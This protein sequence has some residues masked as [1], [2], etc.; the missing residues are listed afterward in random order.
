[1]GIAAA[2]PCPTG[3]R[4][5]D[6]SFPG[7]NDFR[8]KNAN[9]EIKLLSVLGLIVL[10]GGGS[11]FALGRLSGS[12]DQ[13]TPRPPKP[14]SELFATLLGGARHSEGP[15]NAP[16]T[17]LEFADFQCSHC[18]KAFDVVSPLLSSNKNVRFVFRHLPLAK[19]ER[20]LPA[21]IAAEAAGRQNKFWPM[22]ALLFDPKIPED[23]AD[24]AL[25]D[26]YFLQCARKIGLDIA[27]FQRDIKDPALTE[28]VQKDAASAV[29][30]QITST[31]SFLVRDA[32][33]KVSLV[34]G[35]NQLKE[36]LRET[37]SLASV[38]DKQPAT[39]ATP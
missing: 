3:P 12:G 37:A 21:A 10:L 2:V 31:P 24:K 39:A 28:I 27:R 6:F 13:D 17:V 35:G 19:H 29:E 25:T 30:H 22:Y 36:L 8:M 14:T 7:I 18:R 11:L 15:A 9:S 33:G 26:A 16:V 5:R 32:G 1:V 23:G 4:P 34:T 20:A 38:G